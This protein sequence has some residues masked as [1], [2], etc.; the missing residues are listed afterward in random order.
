MS[1]LRLLMM[2]DIIWNADNVALLWYAKSG[3]FLEPRVR[4]SKSSLARR[5]SRVKLI[6]FP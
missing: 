2:R 4:V 3:I 5:S 6:N 1:I